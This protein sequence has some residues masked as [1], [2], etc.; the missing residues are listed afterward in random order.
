MYV[1]PE[2]EREFR[3]FVEARSLDLRRAAYA[4]SGDLYVAEDLVQGA[5]TKLVRHWHKVDD[6]ERY[7]RRIIY[8]DQASRWR[9]RRRLREDPVETT[10]EG[11]V[12]DQSTNVNLRL[13]LRQALLR[14][15]PR[16][17]AVL[18]LRFYQDLPEREI[19]DAMNCSVGTVR[20]QT[21][22]ALSRLRVL[23]PELTR[24]ESAPVPSTEEA[25]R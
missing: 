13:D 17:R 9:R 15:A 19:A 5:L 10:P 8:H 22:R 3:R 16:Q 2:S 23:A 11:S 18:V 4:L 12:G 1:K 25:S 21:A 14:L 6:P 7:V 20:S 24:Y